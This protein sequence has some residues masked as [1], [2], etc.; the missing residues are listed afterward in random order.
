MINVLTSIDTSGGQ[1]GVI[2][3]ASDQI[4][5]VTTPYGIYATIIQNKNK[6]TYIDNQ[7]S[8]TGP[9]VFSPS[10]NIGTI[11]PNQNINIGTTTS[12][13]NANGGSTGAST[14]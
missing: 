7:T 5:T 13:L 6:N 8:V 10:I 14:V 3:L 1:D 2:R 11:T 4:N 9:L 12:T